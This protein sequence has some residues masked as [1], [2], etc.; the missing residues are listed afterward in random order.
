MQ[1]SLLNF[2]FLKF[3]FHQFHIHQQLYHHPRRLQNL[4]TFLYLDIHLH[5][6]SQMKLLLLRH[7]LEKHNCQLLMHF[8]FLQYKKNMLHL[9]LRQFLLH[10]LLQNKIQH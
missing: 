4:Q 6:C 3:Q 2:L 9:L 8:H 7:H 1:R 5:C 10:L